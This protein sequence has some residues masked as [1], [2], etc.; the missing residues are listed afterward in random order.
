MT[1]WLEDAVPV[2]HFVLVKI[3][4]DVEDTTWLIQ[5][6]FQVL[7]YTEG[8]CWVMRYYYQGVCSW[9]WSVDSCPWA[10][11]CMVFLQSFLKHC[12]PWLG[13]F[14]EQCVCIA[15][16][17]LFPF[18]QVLSLPLCSICFGLEGSGPAGNHLLHW[19]AF[20]TIW[21]AYGCITSCKVCCL[22]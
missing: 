16:S 5:L 21:P 20:Q 11:M 12:V 9:N 13:L 15:E 8:L 17:G 7:K 4:H 2:N 18:V 1:F 3:L 22:C 10:R 14:Y 19:K 6:F